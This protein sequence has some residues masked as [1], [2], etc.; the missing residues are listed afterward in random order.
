MKSEEKAT[1]ICYTKLCMNKTVLEDIKKKVVPI[2]KETRETR[3]AIFGSVA[4]GEE[5][6]KSD[7]DILVNLPRDM[8]LFD[9]V[10]LESKLEAT[11][12]RKVDLV[13]YDAIKPRLK[14][15]I[16]RDQILIL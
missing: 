16:L 1:P 5:T 13:D 6:N 2:L 14:P 11:I 12:Q 7:V 10:D 3:A 8:S 4:R 9:V 15:Y